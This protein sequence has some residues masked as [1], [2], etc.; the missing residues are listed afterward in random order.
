MQMMMLWLF[1]FLYR[2]I[3][4]AFRTG[5]PSS[6]SSLAATLEKVPT[7]AALAI[8]IKEKIVASFAC[9]LGHGPC[10]GAAAINGRRCCCLSRRLGGST[11]MMKLMCRF[12]R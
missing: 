8:W 10:W 11:I 6:L 12:D 9:V 2:I 1:L 7:H 3:V 4:V 5:V